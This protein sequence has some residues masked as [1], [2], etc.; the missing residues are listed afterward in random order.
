MPSYNLFK[1]SQHC[2]KIQRADQPCCAR[3]SISRIVGLKLMNKPETLLSK[4]KGK[5]LLARHG[6][7]RRNFRALT[8]TQQYLNTLS[9]PDYSR[10]L[11]KTTQRQI[12]VKHATY[13]RDKLRG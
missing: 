3:K 13:S 6:Y 2:R 5:F 7:K 11:K 1:A 8:M 10:S 4:G 12:D 9:Q